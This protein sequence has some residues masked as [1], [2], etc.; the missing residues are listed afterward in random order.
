MRRFTTEKRRIEGEKNENEENVA[1]F[2]CGEYT[3]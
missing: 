3:A 1:A 2:L